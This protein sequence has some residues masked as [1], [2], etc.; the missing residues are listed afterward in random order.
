MKQH[1]FDV[2]PQIEERLAQAEHLLVCMDFDG[3]LAPFAD[4]PAAVTL[5]PAARASLTSLARNEHV[6]MVIISGRN[7]G[8]LQERV[9]I[10]GLIYAGNHGLEISGPGL[11]FVE[12]AAVAARAAMQKLATDLTAHLTAIPEA[13][14]E[15][16]GL[17]LSV[18]DRLVPEESCVELRR[19]VDRVLA[20]SSYPFQ[21][22][23]GDRVHEIRPAV[24]WN[25]GVAVNWI[26]ENLGR[27]GAL[28]VYVGD[29][30]TDEDAFATITD[31]ITV[32]VGA[33]T[34]TAA[35]YVLK[36]QVSV[37][38]F[39]VWLEAWLLSSSGQVQARQA[40]PESRLG[41]GPAH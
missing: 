11:L 23:A 24:K 33:D 27:P 36:N 7:R 4:D 21:L 26:R 15:D 31:G 2:L 18:H 35:R 6:S 9:S 34:E 20:R 19:L 3:T 22:T 17:T 10:P 14:L 40:S 28:V 25:K 39:V 5:P 29:D 37:L 41:N 32:K 12:P 13:R 8:D 30:R 16:K 1:L 38:G